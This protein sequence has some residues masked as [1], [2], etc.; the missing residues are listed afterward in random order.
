MH[1]LQQIVS[2]LDNLTGDFP[3]AFTWAGEINVFKH[4]LVGNGFFNGPR[5]EEEET[6]V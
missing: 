6:H 3:E 5:D 1:L 4:A 2:I